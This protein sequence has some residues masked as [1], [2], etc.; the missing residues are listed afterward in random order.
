MRYL[1]L[2]VLFIGVMPV[3]SFATDMS[4]EV[5]SYLRA[6]TRTR[7]AELCGK[8]SNMTLPWVIAKVKVDA[9]LKSPAN[10]TVLVGDS[11]KFCVAVVTN[12][13]DASVTLASLQG[14]T[15]SSSVKSAELRDRKE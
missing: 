10:Y 5:T 7:S 11:G 12:G 4:V 2:S 6:G 15:F 14:D 1:V 9:N 13:G 3:S 8:V